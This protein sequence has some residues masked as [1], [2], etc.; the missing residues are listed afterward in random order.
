MAPGERLRFRRR[1]GAHWQAGVAL[2]RETD[3]SLRLRDDQGATR[4]IPLGLV[5]V[6][7]RGSRGAPVW[8]PASARAA[9]TEQLHLF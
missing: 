2:G 3:G 9:R 5:E 8:E 7:G 6:T 4:T 1:P